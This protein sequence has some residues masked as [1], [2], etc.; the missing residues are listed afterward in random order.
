MTQLYEFA[1]IFWAAQV[2]LLSSVLGSYG[3]MQGSVGDFYAFGTYSQILEL[4]RICLFLTRI[5]VIVWEASCARVTVTVLIN[6]RRLFGAVP[7]NLFKICKAIIKGKNRNR[8]SYTSQIY[9][10]FSLPFFVVY[11]RLSLFVYLETLSIFWLFFHYFWL[12]LWTLA[13][14]FRY[15]RLKR[16]FH[17]ELH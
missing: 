6:I 13:L 4:V 16:G 9:C 8:K 15:E 12:L 1:G 3:D 5:L 2:K 11:I 17:L 14:F 7:Q 10:Y